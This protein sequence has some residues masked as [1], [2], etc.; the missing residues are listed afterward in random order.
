LHADDTGTAIGNRAFVDPAP[1]RGVSPQTL[2]IYST[3]TT[4]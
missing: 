3:D 1:D 4:L 2:G